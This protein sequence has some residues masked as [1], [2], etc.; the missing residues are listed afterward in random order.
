MEAI[1]NELID[2]YREDIVSMT[3]ELITFP[4]VFEESENEQEPFG[5]PINDALLAVLGL[6]EEMGFVTRNY[7]GY[8]G[9][10]QWRCV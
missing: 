7:D 6:A 9:T 4:S 10:V 2:S 1:L 5:K 8:V 3:K